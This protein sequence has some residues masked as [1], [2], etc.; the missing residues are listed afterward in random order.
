ML[1]KVQAVIFDMDGTLIDSMWVW[2]EI[3]HDFFSERGF[4]F[5]DAYQKEI[6]GMSFT[7]T[8]AYT[9]QLYQ[10]AETV[11]ELKQIWNEMAR[12]K[13]AEAVELKPGAVQFLAHCRQQGIKMGIATSNSRELIRI[14]ADKYDFHS[15]IDVIVTSCDVSKGKPAPDVYLEAARQLGVNPKN[16]LVFEDVI[17]GILAGKNAGMKV[18]AVEDA[19]SA[20]QKEKKIEIADYYIEDYFNI[21]DFKL[22]KQA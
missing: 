11:E 21:I 20:D 12:Q 16:C 2:D 1:D 18:C 7:E 17:A 13:Y 8:A 10:L 9:K 6:E 19:Y 4:D 5:T 15:Y 3:D 14:I 22:A